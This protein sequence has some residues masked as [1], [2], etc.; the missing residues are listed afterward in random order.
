MKYPTDKIR[1]TRVCTR[2]ERLL[3]NALPWV[4]AVALPALVLNLAAAAREL[5]KWN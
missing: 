2:I 4:L 3:H 1:S 5:S